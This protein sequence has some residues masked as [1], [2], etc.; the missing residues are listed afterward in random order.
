M[1]F[2]GTLMGGLQLRVADRHPGERDSED[3]AAH[4]AVLIHSPLLTSRADARQALT[5]T[6]SWAVMDFVLEKLLWQMLRYGIQHW[7]KV[8]PALILERKPFPG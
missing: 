2:H 7:G 4:D 3:V 8:R 6:C 1:L 5:I